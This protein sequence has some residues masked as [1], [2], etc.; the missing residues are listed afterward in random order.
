MSNSTRDI[1][2]VA[3]TTATIVLFYRW[4]FLVGLVE[5]IKKSHES[6]IAQTQ[7]DY[8]IAYRERVN[9]VLDIC[10]DSEM[11]GKSLKAVK[12]IT[13]GPLI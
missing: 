7:L 10:V 5:G 3:T 1:A 8:T 9:K 13:D 12:D 6:A 11:D 2:L 4:L